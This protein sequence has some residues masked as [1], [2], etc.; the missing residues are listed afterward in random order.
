MNLRSR[1]IL[2]Y[3]VVITVCLGLVALVFAVAARSYSDRV[4]I[5]R[6]KDISVPIYVEARS[7]SASQPTIRDVWASLEAQATESNVAILLL[8]KE[9]RVLRA[10]SPYKTQVEQLDVPETVLTATEVTSG[11]W[12]AP[13][14]QTF[15]YVSYPTQTLSLASGGGSTVAYI[16]IATPRRGLVATWGLLLRPLAW[17]GL[18]AF[19]ISLILAAAIGRSFYRPV[20]RVTEAAQ[21]MADGSYDQHVPVEGPPELKRMAGA[22]NA[23][24][25]QVRLSQ[26]RLRDFVAD[27]SHEL[28]SPLTS[29]NGFAQALFDGTAADEPTRTRAA[30]IIRDESRRV[31]LQVDELL[32]LSRIQAG[33]T[34]FSIEAISIGDVVNRTAETF[35]FRAHERG[36]SI[37]REVQPGL[38]VRGDSD[39]LEQV[40][41]NLLDNALKHGPE[42]STVVL[43]ANHVDT[44]WVEVSVG[45]EGPGIPEDK[46]EHVFERFYQGTGVRTGAGLGLAIA[47]EIVVAHGGSISVA[48]APTGGAVFTVRLPAAPFIGA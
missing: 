12:R 8:G 47:R 37:A 9:G 40:V 42:G 39:R 11:T 43:S 21:Q 4:T 24:A 2:S 3:I 13:T 29:I 22:F 18:I 17:A 26:Q 23:M 7:I 6:L 48:N 16:L 44:D 32:D 28:K 10:A 35:G 45:D 15:V 27:V 34:L 1:L 33:Q 38:Q 31:A 20:K 14:G 36:I 25:S 30:E 46:I 41:S 5:E 19:I